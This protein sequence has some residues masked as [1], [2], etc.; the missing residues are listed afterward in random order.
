PVRQITDG[1][2]I[3]I[4]RARLSIDDNAVVADQPGPTGQI[5]IGD[6]PN[7]HED[8][9]AMQ[10]AAVCKPNARHM[11]V[12]PLEPPYLNPEMEPDSLSLVLRPEKIRQD[13]TGDAGQKSIL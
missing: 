12:Q 11:T 7:P 13:R 2:D 9:V 10:H 8:S 5:V 6:R 3:R 1:E 4:R